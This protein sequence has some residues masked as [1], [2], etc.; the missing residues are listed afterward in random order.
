MFAALF[1]I[2]RRYFFAVGG[3]IPFSRKYI[4]AEA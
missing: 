4:A 3:S 2:F 1:F